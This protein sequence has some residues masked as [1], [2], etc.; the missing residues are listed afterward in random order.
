[1]KFYWSINGHTVSEDFNPEEYIREEI[2]DE[3]ILNPYLPNYLLD[4][5]LFVQLHN[6]SNIKDEESTRIRSELVSVY[7]E[8]DN[9]ITNAR[10]DSLTLHTLKP[11]DYVEDMFQTSFI[12]F[13][14]SLKVK[15]KQRGELNSEGIV[16]PISDNE[17]V[18]SLLYDIQEILR[19]DGTDN[20]VYN[21]RISVITQKKNRIRYILSKIPKAYHLEAEN[22]QNLLL[23]LKRVYTVDSANYADIVKMA[24]CPSTLAD[25]VPDFENYIQEKSEEVFS[26][27][28]VLSD[29]EDL[30]VGGSSAF[31]IISRQ[32]NE[33]FNKRRINENN[34]RNTYTQKCR[35]YFEGNRCLA[36]MEFDLG[37]QQNMFSLSGLELKR[38]LS[39]KNE[40]LDIAHI[41]QTE[42]SD[43]LENYEFCRQN[44][45]VRRYKHKLGDGQYVDLSMPQSLINDPDWFE[46]HYDYDCCERKMLAKLESDNINLNIN[47]PKKIRMFIRFPACPNCE[48]ALE[49]YINANKAQ[50]EYY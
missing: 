34:I 25:S 9:V 44:T 4:I 22:R 36:I 19:D 5:K 29:L 20:F 12:E 6:L 2:S 42:L 16:F 18:N 24:V 49:D 7:N 35:K 43:V 11:A 46:H 32:V 41:I 39:Y 47:Y 40:F 31:N 28:P 21:Y 1:M 15:M 23:M 30:N 38:D 17:A 8:I 48:E 45:I 10:Y 37:V 14:D 3:T 26:L 33:Y 13:I 50:I 27:A